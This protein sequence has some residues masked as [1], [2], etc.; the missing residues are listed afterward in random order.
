MW[1]A[2]FEARK[3]LIVQTDGSACP[4]LFVDADSR[5]GNVTK[6]FRLVEVH[7]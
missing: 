2:K 3:L 5:T 1:S 6:V 4:I 7:S